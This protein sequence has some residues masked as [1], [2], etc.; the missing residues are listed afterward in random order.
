MTRGWLF[1]AIAIATEIVATLALK[2]SA[3]MSRLWPSIGALAGYGVAFYCL[4][5]ALQTIPLGISY[6]IWSGV[7]IVALSVIGILAYDQ[8]LGRAEIAGIALILLGVILLYWR[9]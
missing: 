7:G 9:S 5:Q 3:G 4:S 2:S 1:L 6:A 8:T